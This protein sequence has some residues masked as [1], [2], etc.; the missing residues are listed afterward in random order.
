VNS[1]L[2]KVVAPLGFAV[3]ATMV[4]IPASAACWHYKERVSLRGTLTRQVFA[5]PPGYESIARGDKPEIYYVLKVHQPL[6]VIATPSDPDE[7]AV[8]N[9]TNI[10]MMLTGQD[11][12]VLLERLIDKPVRLSGRF[13]A[14]HTGHHHTAAGR[15]AA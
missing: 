13:I 12:Y 10:Q 1:V 2:L 9:V 4:A 5:G 3:G 7:P 15:R 11:Q 6:C 14:A 8:K